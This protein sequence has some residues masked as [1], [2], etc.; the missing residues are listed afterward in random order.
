MNPLSEETTVLSTISYRSSNRAEQNRID[1]FGGFECDLRRGF[2]SV[3]IE[4]WVNRDPVG[5]FISVLT[6][7]WNLCL[8]REIPSV[9]HRQDDAVRSSR[10][11]ERRCWIAFKSWL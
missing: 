9:L 10:T 11:S 4:A 2:P 3:S 5:H 6:S 8:R 1:T 7:H